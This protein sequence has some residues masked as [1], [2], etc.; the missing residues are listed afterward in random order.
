MLTKRLLVK[1]PYMDFINKTRRFPLNS[2][3]KPICLIA[4]Q[5]FAFS[6]FSFAAKADGSSDLFSMSLEQLME[7]E[8][9]IASKTPE[10][11]LGVT[12]TVYIISE[13]EIETYGWRDLR[14]ILAFVP[15]FSSVRNFDWFNVSLRGGGANMVKLLIDGREVQNLIADEAVIQGSFPSHR[16]KRV[17]ILMGS[18]STLY[19]SNAADGVINIITKHGEQGK[20]A[21][22]QVQVMRGDADSSLLSIVMRNE[23]KD[24]HFGFTA[25]TF[26]SDYNWDELIAFSQN[27]DLWSRRDTDSL[28]DYSDPIDAPYRSYAIGLSAAMNDT[29][30]GA[31]ISEDSGPQGYN[32]VFEYWGERRSIRKFD[33]WFIGHNYK[34]GN[35]DG[36]IEYIYTDEEDLFLEPDWNGSL[37]PTRHHIKAE[38]RTVVGEHELVFGYDGYSQQ[39]IF[40]NDAARDGGS[41]I[42]HLFPKSEV[43]NIKTK[44]HSLFIHD[45]FELYD[46]SLQAVVGLRYE[47]YNNVDNKIIPRL[48]LV[49]APDR[50]ASLRFVYGAGFRA[51][52]SFDLARAENANVDNLDAIQSD[53]FEIGYSQSMHGYDWNLLNNISFYQYEIEGDYITT[54]VQR[55]GDTNGPGLIELKPAD[56]TRVYGAEN[57]LKFEYK[58]INGFVSARYSKPDSSQVA[59]QDI[60]KDIPKFKM[61]LGLSYWLSESITASVFVDHSSKVDTEANVVDVEG[62]EV[63]EI[64]DWTRL[65]LNL[66]FGEYD[67]GTSK[68]KIALHGENITDEV[69]YHPLR[70]ASPFQ[71]RQAPRSFR[72]SA[73]ITF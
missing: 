59:G 38:G 53:M 28:P 51:P 22:N 30:L 36:N 64:S 54:L 11:I 68:L 3:M 26:E 19:G 7:V 65:D 5:A 49:Y 73:D 52:N 25:S 10:N 62:T 21:K 15:A 69:Y 50:Q 61:K 55:D 17:E 29:Y 33:Q 13:Q 23:F 71:V 57:M 63:H 12:G 24:G 70:G 39:T 67:W 58:K 60:I 44:K 9:D 2:L 45:S 47:A 72:L 37:E 31:N 34:M 43:K 14:E 4:A 6:V 32:E 41:G 42:I 56:M 18:H 66:V 35:V 8:V 27:N 46:E 48:G 16:I 20:N 40:R 1:R